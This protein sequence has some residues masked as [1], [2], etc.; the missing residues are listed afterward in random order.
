MEFVKINL[1]AENSLPIVGVKLT[2]NSVGEFECW[3]N[4]DVINP[5]QDWKMPLG[6]IEKDGCFIFVDSKNNE[7]MLN[8][9]DLLFDNLMNNPN[10]M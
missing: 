1:S 10:A 3:Y 9:S 2:D 6:Y 8:P 4:P 7:W 5:D